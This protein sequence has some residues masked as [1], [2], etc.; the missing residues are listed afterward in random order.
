MYFLRIFRSERNHMS[1][2]ENV[3]VIQNAYAAF[4]R[5]DIQTILD[6]LTEDVEWILP[7]EG[8]IPQSGT[9]RGR[10]GVASFFQKLS[11]TTEFSSFEPRKFVAEGDL[12]IALGY[13]KAR[14]KETGRSFES[15]WAMSFTMRGGK[16]SNFREYTDTATI[17]RAY[18]ERGATA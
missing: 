8:F 18:A 9:Y 13:Y 17:A 3:A 4:A 5:G 6:T 16:V 10:E 7:G 12:V 15:Q 2:Q 14:A 1:P 11:Q